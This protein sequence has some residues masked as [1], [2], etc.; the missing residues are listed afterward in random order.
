M[1]GNTHVAHFDKIRHA[2]FTLAEVLITLGIIGVVAAM[3]MPALI[4]N[5]RN[6]VVKARLKKFYSTMNQAILLSESVNGNKAYWYKDLAGAQIDYEGN[7]IQ[8][9]SELEKWFNKYLRP[10]LIDIKSETLP[11][12]TFKYIL[13]MEAQWQQWMPAEAETGIFIL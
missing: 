13:L 5:H 2:A 1:E 9:S 6:S 3:T 7:P 11:D 10:Y 8:G 12:G 4:Q